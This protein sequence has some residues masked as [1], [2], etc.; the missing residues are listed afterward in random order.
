MMLWTRPILVILK[1][2]SKLIFMSHNCWQV[3]D[4]IA[5]LINR[6]GYGVMFEGIMYC[7]SEVWR[8]MEIIPKIEIIQFSV[9]YFYMNR[10]VIWNVN[11]LIKCESSIP[12]TLLSFSLDIH[13]LSSPLAFRHKGKFCCGLASI[14]VHLLLK[15]LPNLV[16]CM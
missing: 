14:V 12:T 2:D 13:C 15:S 16:Q 3:D 4:R 9:F 1:L 11:C 8:E 5:I 10:S 6:T 7:V